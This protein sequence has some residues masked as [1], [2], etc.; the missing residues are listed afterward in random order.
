LERWLEGKRQCERK[1]S[2][3]EK[4][5]KAGADTAESVV[6]SLGGEWDWEREAK[7]RKISKI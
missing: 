4:D 6:E 7:E 2:R 5:E 3:D 1:E